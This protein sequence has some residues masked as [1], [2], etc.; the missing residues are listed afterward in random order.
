MNKMKKRFNSLTTLMKWATIFACLGSLSMIPVI[1]AAFDVLESREQT[2]Q[3]LALAFTF[4]GLTNLLSLISGFKDGYFLL[5]PPTRPAYLIQ[6]A[7]KW[8]FYFWFYVSMNS[9]FLVTS[10]LLV[11]YL[12]SLL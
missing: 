4:M 6:T 8:S 3:A 7:D 5:F 11:P 9:L 10:S 12:I 2:L 1:L